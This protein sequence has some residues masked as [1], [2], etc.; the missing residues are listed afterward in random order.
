MK[1]LLTTQV[2]ENYAWL[3]DGSIGTGADA[4]WKPKG[5]S[6]YVVKNFK[7]AARLTETVMAL[8][9]QVET[10]NEY[11][12]EQLIDWMVVPDDYLTEFEQ[13]QLEFDRKITYPAKELEWS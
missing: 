13:N 8:R 3:E 6:E 7:D 12:R 10:D 2:Y 9:P 1:L 4:Y 11:F 5:G